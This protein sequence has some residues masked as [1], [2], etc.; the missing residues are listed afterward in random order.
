M[1]DTCQKRRFVILKAS[2]KIEFSFEGKNCNCLMFTLSNTDAF[3]R[4][5]NVTLH[6]KSNEIHLQ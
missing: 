2:V 5:K 6:H 3:C 1:H 4:Q